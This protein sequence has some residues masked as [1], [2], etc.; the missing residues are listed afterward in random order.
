MDTN[1]T[2]LEVAS[3]RDLQ[4]D[5]IQ[6][7][8]VQFQGC[9]LIDI[10]DRKKMNQFLRL[11]KTNSPYYNKSSPQITTNKFPWLQQINSPDFHK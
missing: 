11:P 2:L 8:P 3:D 10:V 9:T 7:C 6:V 4:C 1:L 5:K